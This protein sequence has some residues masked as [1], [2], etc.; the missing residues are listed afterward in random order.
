MSYF[1]IKYYVDLSGFYAGWHYETD[2]KNRK[3]VISAICQLYDE[4]WIDAKRAFDKKRL[5]LYSSEISVKELA[6][7]I[8]VPFSNDYFSKQLQELFN[9]PDLYGVIEAR[10]FLDS[11]LRI[12]K[13][14]HCDTNPKWKKPTISQWE[15]KSGLS[16]PL[17]CPESF[18]C[19]NDMVAAHVMKEGSRKVYIT[20]TSR[21]TNSHD[22]GLKN[23]H[24]SFYAIEEYLIPLEN[25]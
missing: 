19:T 18:E 11:I 8:K 12:C 6:N 9:A 7:N 23:E 21:R 24:D 15:E 16:R 20:P 17:F 13:V 2:L 1:H 14:H 25:F 3:D 10:T 22:A 5:I 4:N